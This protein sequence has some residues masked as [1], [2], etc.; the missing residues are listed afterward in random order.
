MDRTCSKNGEKMNEYRVLVGRSERKRS[1]ERPRRRW[2]NIVKMD[3]RGID[4]L[5]WT[6]LICL[7]IRTYGKLL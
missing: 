1:L 3:L 7:R 6:G 2:L 5:V 4:W